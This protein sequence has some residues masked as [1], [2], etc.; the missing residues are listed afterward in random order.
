MYFYT[1]AGVYCKKSPENS[2]TS[3][4][5]LS[6]SGKALQSFSKTQSLSRPLPHPKGL[7]LE[8][9][10][11]GAGGVG[12]SRS[13]H[14]W[15]WR[16]EKGRGVL[17]LDSPRN[18]PHSLTARGA[19]RGAGAPL[20]GC[21]CGCSSCCGVSLPGSHPC[22]RVTPPGFSIGVKSCSWVLPVRHRTRGALLERDFQGT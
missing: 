3:T 7:L 20:S 12:V 22:H 15:G 2:Q 8:A 4:L 11:R 5:G 19:P 10:E 18:P 17:S 16:E 6:T 21:P 13:T 9:A 14:S 1:L